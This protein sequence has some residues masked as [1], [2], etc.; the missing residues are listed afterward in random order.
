MI[1]SRPFHLQPLLYLHQH[2]RSSTRNHRRV[3]YAPSISVT[4]LPCASV[5]VT[6]G[7]ALWSAG[8][9]QT[10]LPGRRGGEFHVA[11]CSVD[12]SGAF[13]AGL[14]GN[15]A[16][17]LKGTFLKKQLSFPRQAKT[18]VRKTELRVSAA[19]RKG[20]GRVVF[21]AGDQRGGAF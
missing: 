14:F 15:G 10:A 3:R 11:C 8:G 19:R 12:R 4:V 20:K 9:E 5:I 17:T 16:L 6:L 13:W 7:E 2:S 21:M 1:P 18:A